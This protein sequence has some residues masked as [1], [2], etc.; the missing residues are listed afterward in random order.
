MFLFLSFHSLLYSTKVVQEHLEIFLKEAQG[1]NPEPQHI[2]EVCFLYVQCMEVSSDLAN[3]KSGA[4]GQ[5]CS[6]PH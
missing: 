5:G 4:P 2:K 1:L 6:K 3:P